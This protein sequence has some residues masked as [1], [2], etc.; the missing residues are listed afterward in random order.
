MQQT[1]LKPAMQ[2]PKIATIGGQHIAH[3]NSPFAF[4]VTHQPLKQL[5]NLANINVATGLSDGYYCQQ[6]AYRLSRLNIHVLL[7]CGVHCFLSLRYQSDFSI[8]AGSTPLIEAEQLNFWKSTF[9]CPSKH[10]DDLDV[11]IEECF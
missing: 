10:S 9:S 11:A 6:G 7:L 8:E 5:P 1:P 2:L 3:S 4:A